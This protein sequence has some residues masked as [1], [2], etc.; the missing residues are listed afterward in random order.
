MDLFSILFVAVLFVVVFVL[1]VAY[2][3]ARSADAGIPVAVARHAGRW[4]G[5]GFLT[6]LIC[7]G[8][9]ATTGL[10][11]AL[12]VGAPLFAICVLI[13]VLAG[14]MTAPVPRPAVRVAGLA[15]RRQRDYVPVFPAI[16][17]SALGGCLVL[18]LAASA[19]N[20]FATGQPGPRCQGILVY[21]SGRAPQPV[22]TG[23]LP[24]AA[25]VMVGSALAAWA[26]RTV[27][28]RPQVAVGGSE[29]AGDEVLRLNSAQAVLAG[30]GVLVTAPLAGT[31]GLIGANLAVSA[32][33]SAWA[34]EAGDLLGLVAIA[35]TCAMIA[36][37][38][39]LA[40][41]TWM[42]MR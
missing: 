41:R 35:A 33:Q 27:V 30:W 37:L 4:R 39:W 15:R 6:G 21:V 5:A 14:E 23:S 16:A 20:V 1:A 29:R 28:R 31:A 40:P 9:S 24:T 3:P 34:S 8:L 10:R 38:A 19:G 22:F 25:I 18:L 36:C 42:A 7:A 2:K 11:D 17:L 12:L 32:C 26:L 13:G